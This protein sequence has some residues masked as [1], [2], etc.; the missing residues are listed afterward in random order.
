MNDY[1]KEMAALKDKQDLERFDLTKKYALRDNVVKIGDIVS[2]TVAS[3]KVSRIYCYEYRDKPEC[4]YYGPV[5]TK[6]GQPYK[7][8]DSG[9]LAQHNL[10]THNGV[11]V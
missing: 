5:L 8:G 10:I 3:I 11:K 7:N 1:V 2:N 9:W 6:K 4:K